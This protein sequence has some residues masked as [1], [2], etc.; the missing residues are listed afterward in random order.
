MFIRTKKIKGKEYAYLVE[1]RWNK[2]SKKVK[3]RFKKYIGPV[4]RVNGG[5]VGFEVDDIEKYCKKRFD[6]IVKDLVNFEVRNLGL[7]CKVDFRKFKVFVDGKEAVIKLNEGY[8]CGM[9]LRNLFCF[10]PREH[11]DEM[12]LGGRLAKA[13][14]DCGLRVPSEVFV[15]LYEKVV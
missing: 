7:N 15:K 11:E 1:N 2:K 10:R 5:M 12:Q 9:N 14:V 6:E 8:L 4:Y 13:F 3:Q